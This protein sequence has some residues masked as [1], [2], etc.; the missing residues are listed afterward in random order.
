MT[1]ETRP[2]VG[3]DLETTGVDPE[4]DRIVTAAV[5]EY[6]GGRPARVST[7]MADP[8]VP[9]PPGATRVHGITT[10]AARTAGR[11]AA[12][13]VAEVTA[14]L[15]AAVEDG[16]P[17]VVMNAPFDL[18]MLERE[19][20]RHG[21][22]SLFSAAVPLVLDP[23]ILDKQVDRYR[24]GQRRLED[25]C[26]TYGVA[27][28]GAH[29]AGAD[30]IAAC[31]VTVAIAEAYPQLS[32]TGL[33]DLHDHQVRWAADQQSSLRAHFE[34]TPGKEYRAA[35]VWTDWPL[36]PARARYEGWSR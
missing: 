21:I 35:T 25:L 6:D 3:F 28:G 19:A 1:W 9:I 12:A 10:E 2:L 14:A 7:W 16:R 26:R 27:H 20:E 24:R 34:A 15:V 4:G 29:D 36:V 23:R 8:G 11:P 22:P 13:V 17:L 30:A 32:Q 33:E 31:A 5:V 18:T